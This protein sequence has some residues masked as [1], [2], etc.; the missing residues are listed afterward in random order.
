MFAYLA[1]N[2]KLLLAS[3]LTQS[4]EDQVRKG[5]FFC[6]PPWVPNYG[7]G[8]P[9]YLYCGVWFVRCGF[10]FASY[11]CCGSMCF[12]VDGSFQ[13]QGML[14]GSAAG[15]RCVLFSLWVLIFLSR[16]VCTCGGGDGGGLMAS[17]HLHSKVGQGS[18]CVF[19]E[20]CI[21]KYEI[22]SVCTFTLSY[23]TLSMYSARTCRVS[24]RYRRCEVPDFCAWGLRCTGGGS[25][26]RF[27]NTLGFSRP[28]ATTVVTQAT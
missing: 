16:I 13:L 17:N 14:G 11:C 8:V 3:G 7:L 9:C 10:C 12:N 25:A 24:R 2:A 1:G 18:A 22:K 6:S 20:K 4:W 21:L 5:V 28:K 26:A 23:R 19:V 27:G 15:T